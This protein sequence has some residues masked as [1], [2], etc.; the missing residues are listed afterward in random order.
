MEGCPKGLAEATAFGLVCIRSDR[1]RRPGLVVPR[2]AIARSSLA[3]ALQQ[4]TA[5]REASALMVR[6]VA[7]WLQNHS[8]EGLREALRTLLQQRLP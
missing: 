1:G 7:T 3:A 8:L 4:M 2:N 6:R 5:N